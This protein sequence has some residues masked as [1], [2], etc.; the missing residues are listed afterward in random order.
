MQYRAPVAELD[1]PVRQIADPA[2][3]QAKLRQ[4][5]MIVTVEPERSRY[6]RRS[7][8]GFDDLKQNVPRSS[9]AIPRHTRL[10]CILSSRRSATL[11]APIRQLDD[12][13]ILARDFSVF[14]HSHL[15]TLAS[16]ESSYNLRRK[17]SMKFRT[18]LESAKF[19]C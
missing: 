16:Q 18:Q 13:L 12:I 1:H 8:V 6:E 3:G 4:D 10:N 19:C 11:Y 17:A 14:G 9:A 5:F 2:F 15:L 7:N